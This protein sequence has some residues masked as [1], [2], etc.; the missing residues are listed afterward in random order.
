MS[1]R[2]NKECQYCINWDKNNQ[3]SSTKLKC[4]CREGRGYKEPDEGRNCRDASAAPGYE[5]K[6]Y[7]ITTVVLDICDYKEN[8][9]ISELI[10]QL[11]NEYMEQYP[12][13]NEILNEY[14]IVGP[15]IAECLRNENDNVAIGLNLIQ[16]FIMPT[17]IYVKSGFYDEAIRIYQTMVDYLKIK[18]GIMYDSQGLTCEY[19]KESTEKNDSM[20][21]THKKAVN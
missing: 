19:S 8:C 18:Y 14:D 11:R 12:E 6:G 1:Y 20:V 21:R 2:V 5:F 9:E 16:K 15:K 17:A 7:Y 4:W 10:K 13:Y 3:K